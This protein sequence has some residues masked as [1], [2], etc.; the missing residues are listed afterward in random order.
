MRGLGLVVVL[1]GGFLLLLM[2]CRYPTRFILWAI[3]RK[4]SDDPVVK[5]LESI[6]IFPWLWVLYGVLYVSLGPFR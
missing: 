2:A 1:C 3:W 5:D 4:R 6:L